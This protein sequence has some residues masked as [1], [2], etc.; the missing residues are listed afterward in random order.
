MKTPTEVVERALSMVGS[1]WPY[2]LGGGNH[3]GPTRVKRADGTLSAAGY[4]CW[5]FAWSH[6]YDEPRTVPGF[7]EGPWATVHGAI[8]TDS[9]IE[10][11]EHIGKRFQ[12]VTKP[13]LG[14]LLVFPS[15]RGPDGKRIRIGHVGI[16]TGLCAEWDP[17][18]PQY[19]ELTVVQCQSSRKPAIMKGPGIGWMFRSTFKGA[20]KEEWRTR[21]LRVVTTTQP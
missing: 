15:I 14:D 9:A 16:V 4:D 3:R 6:C 5:G 11:S 17:E 13:A 18:A 20:R 2:V 12:V 7:N 19:G 8:N 10:E 1:S 21:I